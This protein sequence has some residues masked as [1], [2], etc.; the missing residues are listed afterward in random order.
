MYSMPTVTQR[1]LTLILSSRQGTFTIASVKGKVSIAAKNFDTTDKV[2]LGKISERAQ[3]QLE[4][5]EAV[6]TILPDFRATFN[7]EDSPS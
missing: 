6:Q 3:G 1:A 2:A 4:M 7:A 5:L